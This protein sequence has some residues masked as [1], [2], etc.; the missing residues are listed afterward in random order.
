M[1]AAG[2]KPLRVGYGG[3]TKGSLAS[4]TLEYKMKA[5]PLASELESIGLETEKLQKDRDQLL[6]NISELKEKDTRGS[7]SKRLQNMEAAAFLKQRQLIALR[8]KAYAIYQQMLREIVHGSDVV[9]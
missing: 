7:K 6:M 2:V 9:R 8:G 3:N 1:V 5:H 4:H